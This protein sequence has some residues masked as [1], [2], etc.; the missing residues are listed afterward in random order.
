MAANETISA[1]ELAKLRASLAAASA[2]LNDSTSRR[3]LR[4]AAKEIATGQAILA[5]ALDRGEDCSNCDGRGFYSGWP[6]TTCP[7]CKGSSIAQ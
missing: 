6:H 7:E 1:A 3:S 4:A 2:T 5:R